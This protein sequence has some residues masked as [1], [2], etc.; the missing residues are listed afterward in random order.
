MVIIGGLQLVFVVLYGCFF[1]LLSINRL[2]FASKELLITNGS[3]LLIELL[4]LS[5]LGI[6]RLSMYLN[7]KERVLTIFFV[8]CIIFIS[9]SFTNFKV[10]N[11]LKVYQYLVLFFGI[12]LLCMLAGQLG[13]YKIKS[14]EIETELRMHKLFEDSFQ[15]LI[16]DIRLR[17][18]EF[19]NHINT[20]Y[21][22]HYTCDSYEKLVKAQNEYSQV[23]IKE[24]RYN[25]LL[26]AGSPLLIGFLYGKF[27][28]AEKKNIKV[29]YE[30]S[31]SGLN[32]GIPIYKLV[33]IMGNLIKNAIEALES[34]KEYKEL[35]VEVIEN[36][37]Y[38]HLEVRNKSEFIDYAKIELFFRRGY[39]KKGRNRGLGLYNVKSICREYSLNILCENKMLNEENWM[40]FTVN[41]EKK[42][43][44]N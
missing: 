11:G 38:F 40:S 22:L 5:R 35:H 4:V 8:F 41:N 29:T 23:I 7:D 28:E 42:P 1:D 24:N 15:G 33:E 36:N 17:Q 21:S 39:S 12:I 13:K 31:V 27:I 44:I 32:V 34:L 10:L 25:K 16:E 37:G 9:F 3:V 30:V 26:K 2:E 43:F 6:N 18:H 19:D 14:K 20:I